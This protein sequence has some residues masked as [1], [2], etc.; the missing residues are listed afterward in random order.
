MIEHTAT[1][2]RFVVDTSQHS[3]RDVVDAV[4]T[5][6]PVADLSIVDPPLDEVIGSIYTRATAQ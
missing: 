5:Q 1:V 4:L 3:I 2:V 6:L